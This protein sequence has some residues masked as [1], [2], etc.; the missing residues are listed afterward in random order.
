MALI[1]INVIFE[2]HL[3]MVMVDVPLEMLL[4]HNIIFNIFSKDATKINFIVIQQTCQD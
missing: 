2:T 1:M 3:V 4:A